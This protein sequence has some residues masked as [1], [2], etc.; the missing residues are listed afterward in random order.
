M[1]RDKRLLSFVCNWDFLSDDSYEEWSQKYFPLIDF[2]KFLID[3]LCLLALSY[4][5]WV[6]VCKL[7]DAQCILNKRKRIAIY[8][9]IIALTLIPTFLV[10][11]EISFTVESPAVLPLFNTDFKAYLK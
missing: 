9:G 5:R 7:F 8:A 11:F 2:P 4:E 6:L 1:S 3:N 10:S